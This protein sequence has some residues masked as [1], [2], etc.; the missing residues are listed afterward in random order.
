MYN[1]HKYCWKC[2][3]QGKARSDPEHNL[4]GRGKKTGASVGRPKLTGKRIDE[5]LRSA[6]KKK[7][8]KPSAEEMERE[9]AA[10]DA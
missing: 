8:G 7:G 1:K 3:A 9:L 5:T 2:I 6:R 4:D 10:D